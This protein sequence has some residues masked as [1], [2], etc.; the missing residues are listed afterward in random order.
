[1]RGKIKINSGQVPIVCL[2]ILLVFSISAAQS[3]EIPWLKF[4]SMP[5]YQNYLDLKIQLKSNA[6]NTVNCDTFL[7]NG[8]SNPDKRFY[9]Y[10]NKLNE[11]V[12]KKNWLAIEINILLNDYRCEIFDGGEAEDNVVYLAFSLDSN[13]KR[14]LSLIKKYQQ[15]SKL[16]Y[17]VIAS[18][19][20]WERRKRTANLKRRKKLISSV[21]EGNLTIERME[22]LKL[23]EE[24]LK[25][26]H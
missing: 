14:F 22:S 13:P 2:L 20:E 5:N 19:P 12:L 9:G 7:F 24:E 18:P 4:L 21:S 3:K 10:A 15:Q 16:Q 17:V 11:L 25:N 23:I 26:N 1:M 8:I 6:N